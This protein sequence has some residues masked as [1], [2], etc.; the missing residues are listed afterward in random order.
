MTFFRQDW[1]WHSE[2]PFE[3]LH[4]TLS[5]ES[6]RPFYIEK[7]DHV[8]LSEQILVPIFSNISVKAPALVGFTEKYKTKKRGE[9]TEFTSGFT[10]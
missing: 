5:A 4:L 1:F 3:N 9:I 8:T 10:V 2:E 7:E 6:K